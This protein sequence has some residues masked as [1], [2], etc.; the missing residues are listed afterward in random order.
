M[1]SIPFFCNGKIHIM[2]A[3]SFSLQATKGLA[4]AGLIHTP[5]GEIQTPVF[6]PVGTNT[7]VKALDMHDLENLG[8]QII[9]TNTYHLGIRQQL[10]AVI[11]EQA[12]VH[13]FMNWHRPVLTDSGG[14]QV[15]SLGA[16][17]TQRGGE[18]TVK[19]TEDGVAFR[20]HLDGSQQFFTPERA[21]DIQSV[22]GS[23]IIMAFD[24]A[25]PDSATHEYAQASLERTQRW[26]DRCM[27]QW[28]SLERTSVSTKQYQALFGIVQ[29]GTFKDLRTAAAQHIAQL[30]VD[31]VAIGGETIGYSK[32]GTQE[33]LEW[34]ESELP[35]DKPR[36]TMGL[37][38]DPDD[39]VAAVLRGVDM[40]DCVGPTRLARNGTVYSGKLVTNSESCSFESEYA[41]G[42]LQIGNAAFRTDRQVLQP[43]CD[44]FTCKNGYT[45]AYLHHLYRSHELSYY[46]LASIH[47]VHTMVALAKEVRAWIMQ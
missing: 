30:P 10:L 6:M 41:K 11:Q 5:H 21:I 31:G 36:Y 37:G 3:F 18:S 42:R 38:R 8:A 25:T 34:I 28:D 32:Q 44:C 29:G 1:R 40:M 20:S 7:S 47:N 46:R 19:I 35:A 22:I 12:G 4:R 27:T 17:Q 9:L 13:E 33:V 45:R 24:E 15:F 16:Q 23:D 39:I 2:K 14:F 43:G 26:L